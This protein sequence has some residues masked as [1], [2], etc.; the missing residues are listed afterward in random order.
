[1]FPTL[2]PHKSHTLIEYLTIFKGNKLKCYQ[3]FPNAS[4][5][6]SEGSRQHMRYQCNENTALAVLVKIKHLVKLQFRSLSLKKL[7]II[8]SVC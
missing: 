3:R 4:I 7:S 2:N 5:T 1:M 6:H 8:A